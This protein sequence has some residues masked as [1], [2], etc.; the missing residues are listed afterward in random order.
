MDWE[1][2]AEYISIRIILATSSVIAFYLAASYGAC[3]TDLNGLVCML[4]ANIFAGCF[5]ARQLYNIVWN[6]LHHWER[7]QG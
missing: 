6:A 1:F 5:I 3:E 4:I 2:A 7:L